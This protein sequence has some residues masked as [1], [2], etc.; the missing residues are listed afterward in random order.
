ME[1]FNYAFISNKN[2]IGNMTDINDYDCNKE[3]VLLNL[4]SN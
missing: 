4:K 3:Q 1:N 2:N